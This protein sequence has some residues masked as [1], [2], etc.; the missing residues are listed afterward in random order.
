ML[1]LTQMS[2]GAFV[3]DQA[4]L[5]WIARSHDALAAAMAPMHAFAALLLGLLGMAASIL[6]LGRPRYAFRA[7]LGLRTSWLSREIIA[8]G[9]FAAAASLY[10][11]AVLLNERLAWPG[12]LKERLGA[13]AAG[14][15]LLAV[16]CSV[17]V[18]ADTG[19]EFWRLSQTAAKFLL[20]S[21]VLGLPVVLLI[22]LSAAAIS[23]S[24]AA[25]EVMHLFGR[26]LCCGIAVAAGSKLLVEAAIF[27]HLRDRRRTPLKRTAMLMTGPLDMVTI[28]RF[29]VGGIGGVALPLVLAGENVLAAPHH[30]SP[31]FLGLAAMLMLGLLLTG[32]FLE[33]RLFFAAAVPP[34][35]PGVAA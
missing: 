12:N 33:R 7:V 25:R 24:L 26:T 20:T 22:S 17:M 16:F 18:Y 2:V 10:T 3:A 29:F 34:K 8:F 27:L 5:A 9:L 4:L 30:Y 19:R 13:A 15:G 31:L 23:D 21:L 35:M 28:K 32:E 1:V 6:H 11:G 14:L